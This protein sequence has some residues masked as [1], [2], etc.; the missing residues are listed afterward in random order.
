MHKLP[1]DLKGSA[2]LV[3]FSLLMASNQI[4]IKFGNQMF[5]PVFMA[6]ARS[7]LGL[8]RFNCSVIKII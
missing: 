7:I 3:F 8:Y 6:G 4:E 2:Y 5:D 1:V